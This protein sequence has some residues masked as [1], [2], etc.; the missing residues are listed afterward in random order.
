MN[1]CVVFDIDGT[2]ADLTHRLHHVKG[3]RK[4]WDAFFGAM[5]LDTPHEAIVTLARRLER[6]DVLLVMVSGRPDSHRDVTGAWLAAEGVPFNALY[7]R[8]TGDYRADHVVKREILAELRADGWAPWLVIDDR[9]AVVAMW[10]E[11]GLA[12]LQAAYHDDQSESLDSALAGK[13]LLTILV[14]P[15]GSGKTTYAR[16]TWPTRMVISSDDVREDMLGDRHDQTANERVFRAVHA[17]A[18]ERLRHGMPVVIDAT[19]IKRKD[20]MACAALVPTGVL[21]RYTVIDRP[22]DAKLATRGWRSEELIRKHD[23]TFR[24]QIKDIMKGDGL[25]HVDVEV[26]AW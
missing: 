14:G 15:S 17:L 16:E 2:L 20:R 11:E 7:M 22:L 12:C 25:A 13:R 18:R 26:V 19:N 10:R 3:G 23:Q 5:H 21:A 4:D 24:S 1:S 9:P 8:K 6:A